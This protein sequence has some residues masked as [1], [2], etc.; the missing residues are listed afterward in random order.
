MPPKATWLK[1]ETDPDFHFDFFLA[2][3]MH[4]TVAEVR[5][6]LSARERMQWSVYYGRKAQQQQLAALKAK[7]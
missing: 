6:T 1:L 7:R 3:R 4:R 2:E 5:R